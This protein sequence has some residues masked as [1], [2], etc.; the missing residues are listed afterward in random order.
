MKKMN[1]KGFTLIELLAVIVV[2]AIIMVIATQ[3]INSTIKKSRANSFYDSVLIIKKNAKFV[4]TQDNAIN[5]ET[6]KEVSDYNVKEYDFEVKAGSG[7]DSNAVVTITPVDGGKFSGVR[8]SDYYKTS[9]TSD[10]INVE[11]GEMSFTADCS[12]TTSE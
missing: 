12:L 8:F 10:G 1:K 11:A 4:C 3:Q 5:K 2:L 6:L 7:S 9:P